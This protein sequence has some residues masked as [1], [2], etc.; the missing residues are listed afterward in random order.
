[1]ERSVVELLERYP[2]ATLQDIYKTMFQD[3][4][5]VAHMLAPR[6]RVRA[7][8]AA[9]AAEAEGEVMCYTEECGWRGDYLRVDLRAIR[10]GIISIDELT[11]A[12]MRSGELAMDIN[13]ESIAAWQQEWSQI[14]RICHPHLR[15]IEGFAQDSAAI[16]QHIAAGNYVMH[17]SSA[18][19]ATYAPHYRIVHRSVIATMP[20]IKRR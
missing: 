3:R 4:F 20:N 10:D 9:E 13:D 11:D 17:H 14:L 1:M 16:A 18:Y 8:I 5:G 15:D 6:E 19:N 7:Y 12:F 2:A